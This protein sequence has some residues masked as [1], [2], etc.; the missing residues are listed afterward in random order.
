VQDHDLTVE[1]LTVQAWAHLD[2]GEVARADEAV[3]QAV[4]RARTCSNSTLLLDALRV[5]AMVASRQERWAEAEHSIEE[6]LA[7]AL[8]LRS[9]YGEGRFLHLYGVLLAQKGEPRPARE[10]LEAALAIFQQLGARKDAERTEHAIA[11]LLLKP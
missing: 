6:G 2:L 1:L 10:R 8:R 11:R 7:L 3:T 5:R 4:T 9:L